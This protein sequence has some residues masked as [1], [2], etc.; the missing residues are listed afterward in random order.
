MSSRLPAATIREVESRSGRRC[1]GIRPGESGRCY[2]PHRLQ[3]HHIIPKG[4][5]GRKGLT[6]QVLD[7]PWNVLECCLSCHQRCQG[8]Y[9]ITALDRQRIKNRVRELEA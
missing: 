8:T 1:E 5:G 9:K 4:M 6:A 7:E 3:K 2:S